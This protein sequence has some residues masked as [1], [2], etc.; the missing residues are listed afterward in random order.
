MFNTVHYR[1]MV[2]LQS[3]W[4]PLQLIV[5]YHAASSSESEAQ[6]ALDRLA[7]IAGPVLACQ[8]LEAHTA[9]HTQ[10]YQQFGI[11]RLTFHCLPPYQQSD[12]PIWGDLSPKVLVPEV[13]AA[14]DAAT[15][16]GEMLSGV[17]ADVFWPLE[18][19]LF[20]AVDES[21]RVSPQTWEHVV[22]H[23]EQ[24][25]LLDVLVTVLYGKGKTPPSA[26]ALPEADHSGGWRLCWSCARASQEDE[27]IECDN[28]LCPY[29]CGGEIGRD[30]WSWKY[31]RMADPSLPE[32]P[33]K[34]V[35]YPPHNLEPGVEHVAAWS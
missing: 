3:I 18:G 17:P 14:M 21:P 12:I 8:A 22:A 30:S 16:A 23:P 5:A 19:A 31:A 24:Y 11:Q 15:R 13:Q 28:R 10:L 29:G 6:D 25:T 4:A 1:V 7:D 26:A 2:L 20:S 32:A 34:W 9:E 35:I 33:R 27:Y